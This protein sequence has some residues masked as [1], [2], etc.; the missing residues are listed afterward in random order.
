[1]ISDE[2]LQLQIDNLN[3]K[4]SL[5]K[6]TCSKGVIL[7]ILQALQELKERRESDIIPAIKYLNKPMYDLIVKVIEECDEVIEAADDDEMDLYLE[8]GNIEAFKHTIEELIDTQMAC[9]TVLTKILPDPKDRWKA[10]RQVI[11]KNR[12]RGYYD[13]EV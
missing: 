11:E 13:K 1:M 5:N 7:N 9:E 8:E 2:E 10:R 12:V 6:V 3:E 4:I